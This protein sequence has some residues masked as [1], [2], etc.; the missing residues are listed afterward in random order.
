M[1]DAASAFLGPWLV[2]Y[3]SGVAHKV[4]KQEGGL[5]LACRPAAQLHS[6]YETWDSN[7][8]LAGFRA[9]LHS[10]CKAAHAP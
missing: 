4:V 5:G 7:P 3:V 6:S 2:N 8:M 10:G 9:C 1:G